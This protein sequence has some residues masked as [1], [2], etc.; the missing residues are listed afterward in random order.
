MS[1]QLPDEISINWCIEDVKSIAEDL[2]DEECR[3]VLQ[4]AKKNHDATIGIN[5]EV[6]EMWADHVRSEK[7]DH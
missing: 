6:L 5:W 1:E 2:T 4:L 7:E 3:K